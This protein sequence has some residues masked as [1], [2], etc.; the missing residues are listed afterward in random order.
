MQAMVRTRVASS[1]LASVGYDDETNCLEVEFTTGRVYRYYLVQREVYEELVGTSSA[2]R[3][4]NT[5]IRDAYPGHR[6][7]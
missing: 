3:Y 1:C 6:V 2:G 7:R 4:F 5:V